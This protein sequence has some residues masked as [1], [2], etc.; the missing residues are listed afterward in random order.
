MRHVV[1]RST[2]A[3]VLAASALRAQRPA[4]LPR[5]VQLVDSAGNALVREGKAPGLGVAIALRGRIVYA[6][7][8]G[9]ADIENRLAVTP[10]S[11]FQVGSVT[12]QFTSAAILQLV[13]AGK[14]ALTDP[15]TKFYPD[16]PGAGSK[17][18]V[19][20]LLSHTSGIRNYTA[21]PIFQAWKSHFVPADSMLALF[22][23]QTFDFEPGTK[24]NYSNSGY[25]ILG[26]LVEKL[27]GESYANYVRTHLAEPNGLTTLRYC[28]LTPLIPNRVRGY[29]TRREGGY[30]NASYQEMSTPYAAGALCASASD[31]VKWTVA[32]QS[33][34]VV[35]AETYR[36]MVTPRP[37]AD[38]TPQSYAFGLG[39]GDL[40]GHRV[41]SHNGGIDGFR[42]QLASYPNDSLVI[43]VLL[44]GDTDLPDRFEKQVARWALGVPTPVVKDLPVPAALLEQVAGSYVGAPGPVTI[45]SKDGK[46]YV[47]LGALQRLMY[48]GGATFMID[49]NA[50]FVLRFAPEGARS[51]TLTVTVPGA[52]LA[53]KRTK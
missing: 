47:E 50:D 37:L 49:G 52:T 29:A 4:T 45:T 28:D 5:L 10:A 46:L 22:K 44:N 32:L 18:T 7:G 27:S 40:G 30:E 9:Y 24:W 48:Q 16:W 2:V 1:I 43:A 15:L 39:V 33:G 26:Q 25:Y 35:R 13:E 51:E 19:A 36:D 41:V 12:K 34:K 21:I 6:K 3:A 42:S 20:H 8:F 14:L 17:V 31:L 11:V 38:G 23:S 53:F